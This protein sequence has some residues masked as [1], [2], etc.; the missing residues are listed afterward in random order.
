M[1]ARKRCRIH[2]Q[3][4]RSASRLRRRGGRCRHRPNR[5]ASS[6]S[7][8]IPRACGGARRGEERRGEERRGEE[9]RGEE[10]RGTSCGSPPVSSEFSCDFHFPGSL[11]LSLSLCTYVKGTSDNRGDKAAGHRAQDMGRGRAAAKAVF[12]KL[13]CR[14]IGRERKPEHR[15]NPAQSR[16]H[17]FPQGQ[18]SLFLNDSQEAVDRTPVR[19]YPP[20][21]LCN[22]GALCLKPRLDYVGRHAYQLPQSAAARALPTQDR[23]L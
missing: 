4:H 2:E 19:H 13:L 21:P 15:A 14:V 12:P 16:R 17:A 18:S 5:V 22:G 7:R 23:V 10:R 11:S 9:R 20:S 8:P 3:N 1:S 6:S